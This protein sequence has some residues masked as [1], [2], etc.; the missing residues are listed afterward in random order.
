M[1]SQE[2]LSTIQDYLLAEFPGSKIEVKY[3]PREKVHKFK[4]LFEGKSHHAIVLDSFLIACREL[5]IMDTLKEFT[6]AEHLRE[7][8]SMPVIVAPE[9][10]KLE[11]D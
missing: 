2:K 5:E 6:L 9:G 7:L 1:S 10:L 11:G 3:E 8:G 4:I